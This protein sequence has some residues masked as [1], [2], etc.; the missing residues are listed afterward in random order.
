MYK[1]S[2]KNFRGTLKYV[3]KFKSVM[4]IKEFSSKQDEMEEYCKRRKMS[5]V[6]CSNE[7]GTVKTVISYS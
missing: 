3:R 1:S 7:H 5:E 6:E 2:D 4:E